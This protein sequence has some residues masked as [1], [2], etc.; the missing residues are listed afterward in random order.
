MPDSEYYDVL[1]VARDADS[2]TVKKAYRQ[3]ALRWHPDKNPGDATAEARF[4]LAAEAYAV[5]SDPEQRE[6]YDRLG[7]EGLRGAGGFGGFQQDIFAD[8]SDILG[9]LF[10]LGDVFGGGRRGRR[11]RR[12][13]DLRYDLELDL[14]QA[15]QGF[16]T[17]IRVAR[18]ETCARCNGTGAP[19]DGIETC[20]PCGGRGQVAFQQGFFTIARACGTCAGSGKRVVRPCADCAGRGQVPTE[21]KLPLRVPA[22]IDDGMQ[23][24]LSGEGEAGGRGGARGDLYVVIHVRPHAVFRREERDLSC[25]VTL[26][27]P[28]AALGG[29]V[30]VPT[31]D[32]QETVTVA[33]GTQTGARVRLPGRGLPGVDGAPRGDLYVVFLVRTPT[34]LDERQRELYAELAR[35]EGQETGQGG[36]FDRVKNIF[37]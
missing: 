15:A 20:A 27:F 4:K 23:L 8:F 5:L 30:R 26:S 31:L 32:G 34:R 25:D 29:E 9:D 19:R 12:G 28:Q 33:A 24:R 6:R 17:E 21:R 13:Q 36:L 22:G 10:G 1:G 16:E 11:T 14:E 2:A 3:A 7:R 37:G 35:I 18:H